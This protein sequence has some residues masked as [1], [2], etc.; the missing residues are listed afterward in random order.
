MQSCNE[1]TPALLAPRG[2]RS[3]IYVL[4][5][6]LIIVAA[7]FGLASQSCLADWKDDYARGLEAANDGK[8]SDVAKYMQ[9]ALN[10]NPEP[11]KRVRLYGQRWET[12]APQHYAGLAAYKQGNC[13]AAQRLWSS[14]ANKG[15]ISGF[16][17]LAAVETQGSKDCEVRLA[18]QA[19]PAKPP[20][21]PPSNSVASNTPPVVVPKP[22]PPKPKPA[23]PPVR[24]EVASTSARAPSAS[25]QLRPFVEGYLAG[26][27]DR[28][29]RLSTRDASDARLRAQMQLFRAAAAYRNALLA[30]DDKGL[31]TARAAV[32]EARK[33]DPS[34]RPDATF[35]PPR[36]LAFYN[37]RQ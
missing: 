22:P 9:D 5:A 29:V 23:P 17:N 37:G 13:A 30:G 2:A 12:Y 24:K 16:S 32:A 1:S 18:S 4:R 33:A 20:E 3:R 14:S 6:I 34:L 25:D 10:G 27:Y 7:G 35:F 31:G 28:V 21:N 11:A 26:S 15:F 8:W 19:K 36:F